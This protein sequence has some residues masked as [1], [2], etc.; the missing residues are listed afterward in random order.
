[1]EIIA[2]IIILWVMPIFVA[3]SIGKPK[4]RSGA[5][6]GL[7]LGWIGVIILALLPALP[8]PTLADLERK[9]RTLRP[10]VYT[11]LEAELAAKATRPCPACK[12]DMK[13]DA[14][15]CPHC[16][17][18][19]PPWRYHDERWWVQAD[20]AWHYLDDATNSWVEFERSP[21]ES[22]SLA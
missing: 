19:S 7:L 18:E 2:G 11:Q 20:G 14:R 17:S 13:R 9:K 8:E 3:H 1:M 6:W 15:I 22:I 16:R 12:E 21:E 4:N 5:L 10:E